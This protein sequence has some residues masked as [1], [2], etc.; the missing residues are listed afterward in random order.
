M[1]LTTNN[2][3]QWKNIDIKTNEVVTLPKKM[4]Q[5]YYFGECSVNMFIS[6]D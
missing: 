1:L 3:Y 4:R 5:S 6:A 2:T